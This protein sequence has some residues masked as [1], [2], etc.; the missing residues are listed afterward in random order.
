MGQEQETNAG[1]VLWEPLDSQPAPQFC[2]LSQGHVLSTTLLTADKKVRSCHQGIMVMG[3][4][5]TGSGCGPQ[6]HMDTPKGHRLGESSKRKGQVENYLRMRFG[7]GRHSGDRVE[8]P[9]EVPRES[10]VA[11]SLAPNSGP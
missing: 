1:P 4:D 7:V 2:S 5:V 6:I 8:K 3:T 10:K 11:G 9:S